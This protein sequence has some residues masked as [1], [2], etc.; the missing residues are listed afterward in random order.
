MSDTDAATG[1]DELDLVDLHDRALA[2]TRTFVAGITEDQF[3]LPTPCDDWTVYE[4]VNHLVAGNRWVSELA[5]GGTIEAVGDRFDGDLIAGGMLHAYDESAVAAHA[6]FSLPDAMVSPVAVSYG[7]VPGAVYCGH[8]IIDV[9]IHGWDLAVATGQPADLDP[10]LVDACWRIAAP[11]AELLAGSG[12]FD[13]AL[14][15]ADDAGPQTR[16]LALLGRAG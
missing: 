16:L 12:A 1:H 6:A 13:P 10:V 4:L 7:P 15:V 3:D 2:S 5:A 14:E 9:L 11:Q 8:R